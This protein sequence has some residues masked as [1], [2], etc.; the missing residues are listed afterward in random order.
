[1][2]L[3]VQSANLAAEL[4]Q[5]LTRAPGYPA[6]E[7]QVILSVTE[8]W[9]EYT[10]QILD[11]L[12]DSSE[13]ELPFLARVR[14]DLLQAIQAYIPKIQSPTPSQLISWD[15]D[16]V[17]SWKF[18]RDNI[19][20]LFASVNEVPQ[21]HLLH[22]MAALAIT[23]L[24][25]KKWLYL[26]AVLFSINS[27]S[28]SVA[29]S[30]E[31]I[32][33][34]SALVGSSM[35]NDISSDNFEIPNKLKRTAM[36]FVDRY[37][38]FIKTHPVFLPPVL[39]FLF[40]I[41]A[42]TPADKVRL[43]DASARSLEGLC[44]SCRKALTPHLD[45]LLQQCPQALS[46][47][48]A[49]NYQKEKV[50]AALAS[51]IQALL[52]EE[53]KAAPLLSLIQVVEKDLNEAIASMQAGQH[54]ESNVLGT[55]ALQCL[56]SI[57]RGI[58]A[59]TDD[60]IDIDSEED[61]ASDSTNSDQN[62]WSSVAGL[63]IQNRIVQCFSIVDYLQNPGDAMDAACAILRSGLQETKPGPFV[64]APRVIVAFINK[65][66]LDTPRV[67]AIIGT[68]CS[69]VSNCSRSKSPHMFDEVS[70]VYQ[71]VA[72]VMQQLG[73]PSNDP[74]LAQLCI[75][76]M[77]R[78]LARYIDVL[79]SPSDDEIA[80]ALTFVTNCMAGNAPMLK[81]NA[82]NFFVSKPSC[83]VSF[84]PVVP[85]AFTNLI[86]AGNTAGPCQSARQPG[87]PTLSRLPSHRHHSLCCPSL[88]STNLQHWRLG[89]EI[90]D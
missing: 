77:Q 45:E 1:M 60:V 34:L 20:D 74:Q 88:Y 37:S 71:R 21:T 46:G 10:E 2:H 4:F 32:Q 70:A 83:V 14:T 29:L 47:P 54:E 61:D 38:S 8:F 58:Q 80:A 65:A 52:T 25:E 9:N 76:F 51:I 72:L 7:D 3:T 11:M 13:D 24:S 68:A 39:T 12:V 63:Q 87:S 50:M 18:F 22:S 19:S 5:R 16:N 73:D 79:L 44:S 28:D 36:V 62:F 48:S 35:F 69:F 78:L 81:R 49:N 40:T 56:A 59:P 53:A 27:I 64:F 43:A 86:N 31:N 75:D 82:C 55:T 41:L 33:A 26:E 15:E 17:D 57:G 6:E 85:L 66:Q 89:T 90:G 23:V 30:D 84:A 42:T 67:E